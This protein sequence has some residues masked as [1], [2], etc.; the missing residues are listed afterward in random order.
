MADVISEAAIARGTF[1]LHFKSKDE[2]FAELVD[3][4][5]MRVMDV[6]Q[7]VEPGPVSVALKQIKDN[8]NRVV[9]LLFNHRELTILVL[10]EA[11]GVDQKVES[12]LQAMYGFLHSMVTG[13]LENGATMGIIRPVNTAVAAPALIGAIKEVLYQLVVVQDPKNA[14]RDEV[15]DVLFQLTLRGL[16]P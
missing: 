15:A 2:L 10:R 8:I 7:R 11:V 6:V 1:Y 9:D 3:R 16:Q 4:F 13:A 12:K 5:V 14:D